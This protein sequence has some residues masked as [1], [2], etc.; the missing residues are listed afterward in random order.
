MI[1]DVGG[2]SVMHGTFGH[3]RR[4]QKNLATRYPDRVR[5][6]V[7]HVGIFTMIRMPGFGPYINAEVDCAALSGNDDGQVTASRGR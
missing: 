2:V 4:R 5:R 7:V 6:S 1:G 3:L